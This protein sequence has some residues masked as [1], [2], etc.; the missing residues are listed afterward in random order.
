MVVLARVVRANEDD[1]TDRW[2]YMAGRVIKMLL[3]CST[4]GDGYSR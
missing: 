4:P 2:W 1:V 3:G